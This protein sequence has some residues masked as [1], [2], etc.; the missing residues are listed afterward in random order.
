M[1]YSPHNGV[2]YWQ[3]AAKPPARPVAMPASVALA[4]ALVRM[5]MTPGPERLR[6][7]DGSTGWTTKEPTR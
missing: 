6:L 5:A 4:S 3:Q 7:P 2:R 1:P